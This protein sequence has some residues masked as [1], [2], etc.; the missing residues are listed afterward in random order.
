MV[1]ALGRR[2]AL[3]YGGAIVSTTDALRVLVADDEVLLRAG[4]ARLL[5]DAGIEV[6]AQV[7]RADEVLKATAEHMPDIA[8]VD[9]Q[10]PPTLTDDGLQAAISIRR[11]HPATQVLVLSN[12]LE[13]RYLLDLIGE[14]AGGV[15]YLLKKRVADV[16]EFLEA[17]RRV[18]GG[19]SALD[20]DVVSLMVGR[21]RRGNPLD[22][23]T[24]RERQVLS[25]M[26]E[27]LSNAGVADRLGV[28]PAAVEKH[29][30]SL[31]TKLDL[32]TEPLQHR[33]VMAVLTMLGAD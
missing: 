14:D 26:A 32:R 10:M 6:V 13:E 27:G 25:L 18:A 30:T 15:G 8:V 22:A 21:R 2:A 12:F 29:V 17:V 9:V 19:G 24:T 16:A 31:F 20:P 1:A 4:I 28:T 23:L 3:G 7:G 11:E 5:Q 33:R